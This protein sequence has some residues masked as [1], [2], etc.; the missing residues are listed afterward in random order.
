MYRISSHALYQ[1]CM[2]T[3]KSFDTL[4]VLKTFEKDLEQATQITQ[5]ESLRL[6]FTI[7]PDARNTLLLWHD[8]VVDRDVCAVVRHNLVVTVL[9]PKNSMYNSTQRSKIRIDNARLNRAKK[10]RY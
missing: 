4:S 2:R 5:A 7:K 10:G 1:Y 3:G 8:N 9:L 6:G